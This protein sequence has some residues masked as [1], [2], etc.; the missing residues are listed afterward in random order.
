[1]T[2][3]SILDGV[4][5]YQGGLVTRPPLGVPVILR[6]LATPHVGL[7]KLRRSKMAWCGATAAGSKER[8]VHA[9]ERPVALP[10]DE[11]GWLSLST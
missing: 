11:A 6:L 4:V 1:M 5:V 9:P 8:T 2:A 7:V 10:D 3:K